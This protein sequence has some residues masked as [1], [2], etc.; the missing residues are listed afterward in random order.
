MC[1]VSKGH[2][3]DLDVHQELHLLSL[4]LLL[5]QFYFF[6]QF[7][8]SH[9]LT[10]PLPLPLLLLSCSQLVLI[11]PASWSFRLH[12]KQQGVECCVYP[13]RGASTRNLHIVA[14][15]QHHPSN[16]KRKVSELNFWSSFRNT[17]YNSLAF[18]YFLPQ[19]LFF[20]SFFNFLWINA[21]VNLIVPIGNLE[22]SSCAQDMQELS[23]LQFAFHTNSIFLL[24]LA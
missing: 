9:Y 16:I 15:L 6:T 11:I 1:Q 21:T 8:R 18:I 22:A 3:K 13:Q 5:S 19:R 12:L 20:F 10:A 14:L 7:S 24:V 23:W 17:S 4:S 2:E